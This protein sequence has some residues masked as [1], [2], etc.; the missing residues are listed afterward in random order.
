[1]IYLLTA[2]KYAKVAFHAEPLVFFRAHPGSITIDGMGGKVQQG[3]T[4]ALAWFQRVQ[5]GL[6]AA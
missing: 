3:Y 6:I 1:M 4:K 2:R 5:Q